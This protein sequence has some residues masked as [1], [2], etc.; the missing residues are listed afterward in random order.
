MKF[1]RCIAIIL[2][3]FFSFSS[4]MS[5]T[6]TPAPIE[7]GEI[8]LWAS[9]LRRFEIVSFGSLPF[10]MMLSTIG[11]DS[12]RYFSNGMDGNY[13]PWPFKKTSSAGY[14]ED[15]QKNIFFT[16]IGISLGAALIDQGIRFLVR[17]R[18]KRLAESRQR[19]NIV[20]TPVSG[21]PD[22]TAVPEE[23]DLPA[24]ENNLEKNINAEGSDL[25]AIESRNTEFNN[26][27]ENFLLN[28]EA[29]LI[30]LD[31]ET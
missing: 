14:T 12:Y 19:G 6:V 22:T 25:S 16:A 2:L 7:D 21:S 13:A 17:A 11:Y 3:L 28:N 15:E 9:E 8:P 18:E 26:R 24:E 4:L 23:Q 10:A 29:V 1:H 30:S 20:I 31:K 27:V 5:Q